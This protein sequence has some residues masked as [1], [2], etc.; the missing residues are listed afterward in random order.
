MFLNEAPFDL[1]D[2]LVHLRE[3]G[4]AEATSRASRH[5]PGLWTVGL[6]DAQTSAD[7][8]SDVWER[9]LAGNEVLCTLSGAVEV[10]FREDDGADHVVATLRRGDAVVVPVA[11]WHRLQVLEPA[12]LLAVTPRAR[13]EH[14]PMRATSDARTG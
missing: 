12:Q 5:E 8:H 9:H 14:E 11:M 1:H 13:T 10:R 7:L 3:G 4:V 6:V 2:T